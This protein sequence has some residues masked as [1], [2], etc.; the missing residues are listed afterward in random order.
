MG[1]RVERVHKV[2]ESEYT[3]HLRGVMEYSDQRECMNISRIYE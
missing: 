1:M 2:M 3:C